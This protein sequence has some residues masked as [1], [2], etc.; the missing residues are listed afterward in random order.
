VSC[1]QPLGPGFRF[2]DRQMEIRVSAG[3][4]EQVHI[5]V[6][7][8]FDNVGDRPLRSLEVRLPEGV[9]DGAQ[10]VRMTTD[11]REVSPVHS[12]EVDPRMMRAAFDSPWQQQQPLEIVTQWDLRPEA[13]T[14]GAFAASA[15]AFYIADET[16]LPLW[17]PPNGIFTRGGPDPDDETLTI[18]APADFRVLAPGKR[19]K[20]RN[21][22]VG[23]LLSQ[24][25]R[26]KPEKDFLPFVVAGRYEEQVINTHHGAVGFWTF[27]PLDA[28][29]TQTAAARLSSSMRALTDFFGPASNG[30][31]VIHVVEAPG[32]L[33]AQFGDLNDAGGTSFPDGVLLDSRAF[34]QGVSKEPILQLGEYELARTWFGW[35]VRPS[36]EAQILMG[37][38][39]GLF[40]LVVAA[41]ARGPDQRANMVESLLHRYD[42]ARHV[43]ADM[44][45]LEPS[46]GYSSAERISTGYKAAL[47]FVALEDLC[48]HDN[49]RAAFREIVRARGNDDVGYADLRSALEFSSRRDL[50]GMFRLWLFRP[51]LPDDFR[52]RYEKPA[53]AN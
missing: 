51:G 49:M 44:P 10:N 1:V 39:V 11:G 25:F 4:A 46:P 2:A 24:S 23:N 53:I 52:H 18:S 41:E 27:R 17:Q 19:V 36:P 37:R 14:R 28:Q 31:A 32:E 48:G 12:S 47:F 21:S 45:M 43:A 3:A 38:G 7:D 20:K 50:A 34:A 33:P 13:S 16:A 30:K 40:A 15:A 35:R 8:H 26:L 6:V 5:R 42:A 29:Q 22:L 9:K